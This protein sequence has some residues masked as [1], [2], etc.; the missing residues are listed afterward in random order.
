MSQNNDH[1]LLEYA[2]Y[3]GLAYDHQQN[4]PLADIR[5]LEKNE[6]LE[7]LQDPPDVFSIDQIYEFPPPE[8]PSVSKSALSLL[9]EAIVTSSESISFDDDKRELNHHR[10]RNFKLELPML[11]TDHELDI[12]EFTPQV[13]P[14]LE[15]EF[16]P[17]E[18]M[19]EEADEGLS[20]PTKYS[21]LFDEYA[22]KFESETLTVSNDALIY[23]RDAL[24]VP[25]GREVDAL[26]AEFLPFERVRSS[27]LC[28]S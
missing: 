26:E 1:D 23:L 24:K 7:Q 4:D 28:K 12:I 6:F 20:W 15:H 17:L 16:L 3:Y 14:D 9:Q 11:R 2:R 25:L 19:D 22:R 21:T 8:R 13:V 27:W 5:P 10:V 18:I